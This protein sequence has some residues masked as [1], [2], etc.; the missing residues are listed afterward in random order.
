M[1]VEQKF[2]Q[3]FLQILDCCCSLNRYSAK[4]YDMA[5]FAS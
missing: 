1:N 3:S 2:L 4:N 5:C